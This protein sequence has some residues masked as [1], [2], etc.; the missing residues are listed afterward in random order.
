LYPDDPEQKMIT[1]LSVAATGHLKD[2]K[3]T[4]GF[5][6]NQLQLV[7]ATRR[8]YMGVFVNNLFLRYGGGPTLDAMPLLINYFFKPFANHSEDPN[9]FVFN[10]GFCEFVFEKKPTALEDEVLCEMT[11]IRPEENEFVSIVLP[12]AL[13]GFTF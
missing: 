1:L 12:V 8:R 5:F 6:W 2:V 3:E 11:F 10:F 13:F 4:F 9:R 7:E